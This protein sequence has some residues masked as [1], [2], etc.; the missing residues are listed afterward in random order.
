MDPNRPARNKTSPWMY[1]GCGCGVL[2]F[3]GLAAVGSLAFFGY[4]KGKDIEQTFKDPVKR[5]A[6]TRETLHYDE[7]PA[8]YYPV[9]AFSIPF[10]MDIAILSDREQPAGADQGDDGGFEER[11]F[12]YMVLHDWMGKRQELQDYMEGK[13]KRPD[14]MKKSD[15]N[16]ETQEVISRGKLEI[17]GRPVY[18]ATSRGEVQRRHSRQRHRAKGLVTLLSVDC[19]EDNR[20]R[21]GIWFGPDPDP[22][23]PADTLDL[24]GTTADPEAIK[25]FAGHFHFCRQE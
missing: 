21:L 8:G 13:G 17:D 25:E 4:K 24:S 20:L 2:V 11:G 6:K 23:K 15:V 1:I 22:G 16:L 10:V 14:W 7:P 3:L 12:I 19:P 18:Y 9:G 5:A